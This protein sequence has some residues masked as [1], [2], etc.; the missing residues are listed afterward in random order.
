MSKNGREMIGRINSIAKLATAKAGYNSKNLKRQKALAESVNLVMRRVWDM[1][2]APC[3]NCKNCCCSGCSGSCG[4]FRPIEA[5]RWQKELKELL[6]RPEA[7]SWSGFYNK[8]GGCM[9]PPGIRSRV[10]VTHSCGSIVAAVGFTIE[11]RIMFWNLVDGVT[12]MLCGANQDGQM[13]HNLA[14]KTGKE[15]PEAVLYAAW[16]WA[17]ALHKFVTIVVEREAKQKEKK[18]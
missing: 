18:K 11:E 2:G 10:C 9:L 8:D 6:R 15:L 14:L 7:D 16:E 5:R 17:D 3:I 1:I 12:R 4:H 13:T